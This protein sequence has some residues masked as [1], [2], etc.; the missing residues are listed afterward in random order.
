MVDLLCDPWASTV[1]VGAVVRYGVIDSWSAGPF[2]SYDAYSSDLLSLKGLDEKEKCRSLFLWGLNGVTWTVLLCLAL[3]LRLYDLLQDYDVVTLVDDPSWLVVLDLICS[4]SLPYFRPLGPWSLGSGVKVNLSWPVRAS[5]FRSD[6]SF[7]LGSMS[8]NSLSRQQMEVRRD[9]LLRRSSPRQL[10]CLFFGSSVAGIAGWES[11]M[12]SL[13]DCGRRSSC[14]LWLTALYWTGP[15]D[16]YFIVSWT[17]IYFIYYYIIYLF[18]H[19]EEWLSLLAIGVGSCCSLKIAGTLPLMAV[20]LLT[21]WSLF[22]SWLFLPRWGSW[23]NIVALRLTC[24]HQF[25]G[26]LSGCTM[27]KRLREYSLRLNHFSSRGLLFICSL[28]FT[29][30]LYLFMAILLGY[31]SSVAL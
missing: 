7:F 13:V 3:R 5:I 4:S 27:V 17:V 31:S 18:T 9:R 25:F 20:P 10:S 26:G 16:S 12:L 21:L 30:I 15:V 22:T 29:L 2:E 8:L 6:G 24:Y 19:F 28:L 11:V 23:M 1:S 14:P